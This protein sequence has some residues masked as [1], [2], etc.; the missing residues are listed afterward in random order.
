MKIFLYSGTHWDRE[1][2][3]TFQ[4]FR[5]RLVSMTDELLDGLETL[6][7]YGIFHFDGQTIVLEDY[8]EIQP[9]NENR[10][11]TLI[12]SGKIVIGPWY[13]MP[14]EF[15]L[16]GES[17]IKNLQLG[18]RIAREKFGAEPSKHGYIC[19][20][21]G[22]IAQMPQIF[23]GMDIH[24]A[25]L[26]RGTNE[27][28]TAMHFRWKAPDGTEVITF[29]LPDSNGYGDFTA[30]LGSLS[31]GMP[32]EEQDRR[33]RETIDREINRANAPVLLLMDALDHMHMRKD[34]PFWLEVIRRNYP[35]AEVYHANVAEFM[36]SIDEYIGELPVKAGE[37]N[38][39]AKNLCSYVHL[40]T[41]TLSSRYPLKK[42]N[43]QLQ[44]RLEKWIAPL[45]AFGQT[46]DAVG[47]LHLANKYLLQNHPHDSICGCSI[48]QV[49]RDMLYR[50]DQA[51][52]IA[53][54]LMGSFR[55]KLT[56][57]VSAY[58]ISQRDS[59][60][61]CRLLRV[62][63]P[64]PYEINRTITADVR[65]DGSIPRYHEPF[66]YEGI[67]C[68][69]LYD[70][71]GNEIPYG[72]TE[73]TAETYRITFPAELTPAGITEYRIEPVSGATPTRYPHKLTRNT[74]S[75]TSDLL[76]LEINPNGTI[77]LTDLENGQTYYDLLTLVDDGEIG[78]GWYHCNP[79]IDR[80][81]TANRADVEIVENHC[82]RVTW[83]IRQY[84]KLP[85]QVENEHRSP[86]E[87]DFTV[88]HLVSLTRGQRSVE[89]QTLIDN[90]AKDH[91]LRLRLPTGVEGDTYA[92]NQ[93]FCFVERK[94]GEDLST[95]DWAEYGTAEKQTG[96]IVVKR[97]PQ[98]DRGFA[99]LSAYGIH[100]CAVYPEGTMDITLFR[101][102][103]RTVGTAGEP[104]GQLQ[105]SLE[106]RYL[107]R[108]L[109][110]ED[111]YADLAREQ[112]ILS[113]GQLFIT[114]TGR[115]AQTYRPILALHNPSFLYSTANPLEDGSLEVRI[116]NC[117]DQTQTGVITLPEGVS[118]AYLTEIDGRE[119][120]QLTV[121]EEELTLTLSPWKIAT[122]CLEKGE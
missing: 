1:W 79:A 44:T 33:I 18:H 54:K 23:S 5:Y 111:T 85:A 22:H 96:G 117:S 30:C 87:V 14:D 2:Y 118:H 39:T 60:H 27:H 107:L 84:M 98:S 93:P 38:E 108:P 53:D 62:Y 35:D 106:F 52:G 15:L 74:L 89:V 41:H 56:G 103:R 64:L 48:D 105:Q 57:D 73:K 47:F 49:H 68:F 3:E 83:R 61:D 8:L 26:G 43:D 4:G 45:Y 119:I 12:R 91:R 10:L 114:T 72:I 113:A 40:I 121:S 32:A 75:A 92:V 120:D 34:S 88:T 36:S 70:A 46:G 100:E 71:D 37:L 63:N 99:F 78:D 112:E 25:L 102:F 7:D 67:A 95:A 90:N 42:A 82:N 86:S 122:I 69:R 104:D 66:G 51:N 31:A 77:N 65:L 109:T 76:H 13:C 11:R 6:P 19:D 9:Q 80:I 97:D 94:A 101:S 115:D 59:G 50:F 21:F 17:L 29:K 24:H 16:S 28:T 116:W 58:A 55:T 110:Q 81:V 20:I